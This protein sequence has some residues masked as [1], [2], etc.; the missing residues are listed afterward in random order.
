MFGWLRAEA[1]RASFLNRIKWSGRMVKWEGSSLSAT[2]RSRR[3]V[4]REVDFTHPAGAEELY[5]AVWTE[6]AAG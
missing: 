2:S 1:A 4:A 3:S 6:G 5:D